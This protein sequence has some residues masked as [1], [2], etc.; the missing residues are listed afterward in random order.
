MET[1]TADEIV[2]RG[3]RKGGVEGEGM[4]DEG[5]VKVVREKRRALRCWCFSADEALDWRRE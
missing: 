3:E 1:T 5:E 2:G 4:A